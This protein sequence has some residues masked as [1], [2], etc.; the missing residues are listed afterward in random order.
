MYEPISTVPG[1]KR[2]DREKRGIFFPRQEKSF[3]LG[4]K[5]VYD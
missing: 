3:K 2:N 1:V 4:L 5:N